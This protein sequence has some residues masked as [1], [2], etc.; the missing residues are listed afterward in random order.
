M[1][2]IIRVLVGTVLALGSIWA[3]E[4]GDVRPNV[5]L[6]MTD[7][8]GWGDTGYNGL[9]A[10]KTPAL[11]SMAANG[12]RFDR[13]YSA[14]P[15]C[16]PTR[17]SV[18]SGRHPFRSGV[19]NPGSPWRTQELTL[20]ETLKAAGYA[21]GHFGKWHL[22]GV[23]GPGKPLTSDD[24]L[25]PGH[26]G[27][28]EWLSVSNYFEVD[29]EFGHNGTP[30]KKT[31]DGSDVIVAQ[32]L[33]WIAVQSKNGQPFLAVVWFGN[34]HTPHQPTASDLAAAGGDKYYG[35]LVGVDRA[36]GTLRSGLRSFGIADHTMVWFNS[37][38]GAWND[39]SNG[40]F[41][42]KKGTLFEGGV[43][44]PGLLEWPKRIKPSHTSIP[45]CTSDIY[46]T[47]L[48][49]AGITVA[50][51][52][53]P[54]DGINLMPLL[55]GQ[56]TERPRPIGFW[57]DGSENMT[58]DQG[59]AAWSDNRFKLHK[60]TNKNAKEPTYELYDLVD[61]PTESRNLAQDKPDLTATMKS[62]LDAWQESVLNSLAGK[63]Y[64]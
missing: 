4:T 45:V 63:D 31:G 56:M 14:A 59:H 7:D 25:G 46:P 47:V 36:M 42:G 8:Q 37:D 34:P 26:F 57:H 27:F 18:L 5:I 48:A 15:L 50:K 11:D 60:I 62:A 58:R 30:V 40:T 43:R 54:L 12:L 13:F 10:I 2:L 22:N 32:A 33:E 44:V 64:Q 1:P 20:A 51:Q 23:K 29:W 28:T 55:D 16:S 39:G 19:F 3:A 49:A 9:K 52:V 21:T 38:N 24:P 61:D 17:A 41:R 53:L 35:E 6:C